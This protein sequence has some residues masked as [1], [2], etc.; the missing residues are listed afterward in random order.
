[1]QVEISSNILKINGNIKS[2]NDYK[3]IKSVTD[4]LI[5]EHKAITIIIKDSLSI[6]SSVIG[7]LNKIVLKDSIDLNMQVGNANLMEL[8]AD[9]NL[10]SV[11]KV[12]RV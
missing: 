10:T 9:L 2:V 5:Q 4:N 12:T 8:L 7:Y 6:T 3:E 11:F 1:M